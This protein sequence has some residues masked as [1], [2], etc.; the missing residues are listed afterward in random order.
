MPEHPDKLPLDWSIATDSVPDQG[1]TLELAANARE[2][3]AIAR[4]LE[5]LECKALRVSCKIMPKPDDRY[6]VTGTFT[7]E[8]TQSCVVTLE[9]VAGRVEETFDVEFRPPDRIPAPRGG[10]L[11][12]DDGPDIEPLE[13]SSIPLGAIVFE[14]LASAV[15]P[16]PRKPD[17]VFEHD[18]MTDAK[19]ATAG[20]DNPFSVLAQLK[21]ET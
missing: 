17:A 14:Y 20:E 6:R 8:T 7:A 15:D 2:C 11:D 12:I 9:P 21:R 3:A 16:F 10:E 19:G 13:A 5:L 18:A 4:A 1:Q